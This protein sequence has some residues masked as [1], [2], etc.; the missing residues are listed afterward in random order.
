MPS[1]DCTLSTNYQSL[2]GHCLLSHAIKWLHFCQQTIS[3]LQD[4]VYWAMPSSD[5]NLSTNYQSLAG[6]CL[7]CHAIKWLQFV[8]KLPVTC[9]TLFTVPCHQV[10]AICQQTISHLQDTVYWAMPSSDCNLLTNYQSLAGH[11]LLSHA[12]KWLSLLFT[13]QIS[14]H[15]VWAPDRPS[16]LKFIVIYFSTCS[17]ILVY[18]S[19]VRLRQFPKR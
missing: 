2:A 18:C 4:T 11:C 13:I 12:I 17:K 7:L 15:P 14:R 10:T 9:R 5:C 16:C 8:N 19:Q 6:Y 1:S 3:H